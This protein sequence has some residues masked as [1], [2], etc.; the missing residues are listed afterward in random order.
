MNLEK[1]LQEK[2]KQMDS[3]KEEIT[4]YRA[5]IEDLNESLENVKLLQSKI[6]EAAIDSVEMK[7]GDVQD[8]LDRAEKFH[9]IVKQRFNETIDALKDEIKRRD[10]TV[11][12]KEEEIDLKMDEI[13]MIQN[14]L[15][16]REKRH[17]EIYEELKD[18]KNED[19]TRTSKHERQ[20]F[21]KQGSV[22]RKRFQKIRRSQS[23]SS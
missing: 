11:I 14:K 23:E 22:R 6:H 7:F 13:F 2:D 3:L 15:S 21:C 19:I 16:T 17:N 9:E 18:Q 20:T 1:K 10:E 4:N 5:E 8:K 12:D